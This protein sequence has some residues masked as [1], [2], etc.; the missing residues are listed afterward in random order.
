MHR[1]DHR[2]EP[3][4]EEFELQIP[5]S[6]S[7]IDSHEM[8]VKEGKEGLR[9]DHFEGQD[10]GIGWERAVQVIHKLLGTC[11]W[12]NHTHLHSDVN[13]TRP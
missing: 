6:L 7:L 10:G 3:G 12:K 11:S 9:G 5:R 1:Q 8:S 13:P 2:R 4:S